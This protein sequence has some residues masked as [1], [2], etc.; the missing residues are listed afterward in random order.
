MMNRSTYLR[1][2][3]LCLLIACGVSLSGAYAQ[4]RAQE[5]EYAVYL[6]LVRSGGTSTPPT[7]T[8][9]TPTPPPLQAG[10]FT[11]TDW[12]TYNAATA[13]DPQ[14][15][16]HL[17]FYASDE[18]HQDKPLGQPAFYTSCS[19]GSAAC[20]DPQNWSD[21]VQID[22]A[23]NEV[24]IVV[25]QAGQ[26]RLLIRR[27]G[28]TGYDYDY[29][30][31]EQRCTDAGNWAGVLVTQAAGVELHSADMPQHSFALDSQGRPRFVWS[32]GWG[33]Q[34][35]SGLYYAYCDAADCTEPGSWQQ[36]QLESLETKT[37]TAD[38]ATLVFDG[39]KPRV[40]TRMNY[41]GLPAEVR[42]YECNLDC[43]YR[44]DWWYSQLAHPA[45]KQW[46]N[47]DLALD[48]QGHRRIALYEAAGIDITVGG[49]LYYGWCDNACYD[50]DAPF[51]IVPV[52]SGEGQ[53]VDLAID[54]QGR[55]HLVYDAGQRG[56]LGE[57]WCDTD[58][59]SAASWQRRILETSE[60]LMQQ[61]APASP[62]SC[63]QQERVW[64]DAIPQA[65]FDAQGRL[66]VAY[67]VKNVAR[68]YSIDPA[69]P[70]HPIYSKVERIWW[71]VR[72]AQF[73]QL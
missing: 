31:C 71:A 19:Q 2:A 46:A 27:N 47:W 39:I 6:P 9:P 68:C 7:P 42:Y 5:Q 3:L 70:T 38:Y 22:S 34:R 21:L 45:G 54:P 4:P 41:S 56:A 12:L 37:V 18:R 33:N 32:N 67:D 28:N 53:S 29:W 61:F 59:T 44:Y 20:A 64:L 48:A 16:M 66:V 57:L 13:I 51:E 14:G 43:S 72:L 17:A 24:Q 26:P 58:C 40:L 55:T 49:K 36:A 65:A 10:F 50:G 35:S 15:G 60:Q 62:L 73:P 52:A 8:P 69:D 11:L 23:V 25:T 30:A 1:T 63:D